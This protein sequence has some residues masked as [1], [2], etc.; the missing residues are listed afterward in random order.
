MEIILASGSPRRKELLKKVVD[1]FKIIPSQIAESTED[2]EIPH[3]L[4]INNALA[5]ARDIS[6]KN[7]DAIIIGADTIVILEGKILGKPR[8]LEHAKKMLEKLSGNTHEVITGLAVIKNHK[9]LHDFVSTFVTFKE[10]APEEIEHYVNE[11]QPLDKA[12]SYGIQEIGEQFVDNL[13]GSY[14]NVMGLPIELLADMLK[15][16]E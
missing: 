2:W 15:D 5:K 7:P 10:L 12:G 11:K 1:N 3:E 6:G 8:D 9:E 16:F 13:V 4:A 14:E